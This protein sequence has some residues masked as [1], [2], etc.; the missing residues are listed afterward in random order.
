VIR[1]LLAPA[2]L[3]AVTVSIILTAAQAFA[4]G[5][6]AGGGPGEPI[7]IPASQPSAAT[8]VPSSSSISAPFKLNAP[9]IGSVKL[10]AGIKS[11][12]TTARLYEYDNK[13]GKRYQAKQEYYLGLVDQSGWGAY[14]QAVTSGPLYAGQG[15]ELKNHGSLGAG[16]PSVTL[17]HP[18]WYR[19]TSLTLS[20]QY[21]E[22]FP[23]ADRSLR[24]SIHQHAYY[25]YTAYKMPRMWSVWNQTVTRYFQQSIYGPG[26]TDSYVE[27]LG[28][29]SKQITSTLALGVGQW[30]QVEHHD[31][32]ATGVAVDVEAFVRY[33]PIQNV[34]IEPRLILPAYIKN[35]VYDQAK[36]VSLENARAELYAQ[37]T[38]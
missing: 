36:A 35:A 23:V 27:D 28:T 9:Q 31:Q 10:K 29:F 20:G 8:A 1:T 16:D 38:L 4:Q 12:N 17:L 30:T 32:T 11:Q 5:A 24:L 34:W 37:M 22:Y 3:S 33:T 15:A 26:D 14:G 18:D 7:Q 6:G 13:D 2:V 19:G 25:L 21:R